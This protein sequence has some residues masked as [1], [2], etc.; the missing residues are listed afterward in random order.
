MS[1]DLATTL[2]D[3]FVS[4]TGLLGSNEPRRYL[5]TDAFAVCNLIGLFQRTGEG[6]YL[7]LARRLVD[8]VHFILGRHRNDDSRRGWISGLPSDEG[9]KHPT[10][11]GLR[12]GK[13]LN[14]RGLNESPDS[15]LEWERDGQYFHYLTKWMHA[16]F[17]M[18]RVTGESHYYVWAV[19]LATAAHRAFTF[20]ALPGGPKR[21]AWKMSIDLS[22]P[23]VSS[24]G[25]HD[26]LDGLITCL[27][28][29]AV[30]G[31]SAK[32]VVDLTKAIADM[33]EMCG[34]SSLPTDDPLGIGG[35]LDNATRLAQLISEHGVDR[36][37]LLS[38]LLISAEISL[39]EFSESTL[40]R[41]SAE[42]RLAFRELGLS[43]GI[44]G[45]QW[46]SQ[47]A[48][49]D[50]ELIGVINR[51]NPFLSL[52]KQIRIYWSKPLHQLNCAWVEH[53]DINGV[54]LS[55][56]IAPAGYLQL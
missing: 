47:L 46:I 49:Q 6:R 26:S 7:Q 35:L 32:E 34:N 19:E 56:S 44:Q 39:R 42:Q 41:R 48:I 40:L 50:R 5:W 55:T 24:M 14:E 45:L 8:Q 13:T 51:L 10:V 31:S 11:G 53:R 15:K 36:H 43:I 33:T 21:I 28:L 3:E 1:D 54:M 20:Q 25:Q 27:E 18:G 52:A 9:E 37:E 4:S 16:L 22:R 38:E 17:R 2:M 23:L 30:N 29:K 12:I